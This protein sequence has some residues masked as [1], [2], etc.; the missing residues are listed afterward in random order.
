[1]QL[2]FLGK[3]TQGGGSPA[4]Y[5]TD[6][7]T[8]V[9][10]GWKVS[11]HATRVEIPHRL[12][13]HVEKGKCLDTRLDDTGRGSFILSGEPV[14]DA[15]TLAQLDIPGHETCVEIPTSKEVWVSGAA[16]G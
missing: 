12:L 6:R 15:E 9:V 7:G 5:A 2:M 16:T 13:G 10:Q 8:Y 11:G 1:M 4:L 3:E 14:T